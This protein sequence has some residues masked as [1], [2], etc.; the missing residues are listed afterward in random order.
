MEETKDRNEQELNT[1]GRKQLPNRHNILQENLAQSSDTVEDLYSEE[2]LHL[3]EK[4]TA[5]LHA[6]LEQIVFSVS[7]RA[8]EQSECRAEIAIAESDRETESARLQLSSSL[9][10]VDELHEENTRLRDDLEQI[11]AK[12][13][14]ALSANECADRALQE[15]NTELEQLE[16]Q[17]RAK[18][19][20]VKRLTGDLDRANE[21]LQIS[22]ADGAVKNN[23]KASLSRKVREYEAQLAELRR[24]AV[25]N[26]EAI[27]EL[28]AEQNGTAKLQHSR[29]AGNAKNEA[30]LASLQQEVL[31][32]KSGIN[33]R[34]AEINKLKSANRSL[35]EKLDSLNVDNL[36][37][38]T[39]V[40][41]L[42]QSNKTLTLK[43]SSL[44]RQPKSA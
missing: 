37:L 39:E 34:N 20:T 16:K 7:R 10:V 15:K 41:R 6:N 3:I 14:S 33:K 12:L 38:K 24:S 9:K 28:K 19:Q 11:S 22:Q 35:Q 18:T 21:N 5:D 26:E 42:V 44:E 43:I 36:E 32:H 1:G 8:R 30:R 2:L 13:S 17:L 31:E 25:N 4:S 29:N 40:T 23:E 27:R